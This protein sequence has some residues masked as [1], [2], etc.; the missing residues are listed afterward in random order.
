M[1]CLFRS[2]SYLRSC[3]S[4]VRYSSLILLP[5]NIELNLRTVFCNI[6]IW[7]YNTASLPYCVLSLSKAFCIVLKSIAVSIKNKYI[8]FVTITHLRFV[9]YDTE[10]RVLL[11]LIIVDEAK[12]LISLFVFFHW[13]ILFSWLTILVKEWCAIRVKL[14]IGVQTNEFLFGG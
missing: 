5:T 3:C 11:S 9:P 6:S 13:E 8:F 2:Y 1:F 12:T 10:G 4:I 7:R 14:C